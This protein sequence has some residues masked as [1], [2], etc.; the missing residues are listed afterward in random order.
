MKKFGSGNRAT[1]VSPY[2]RRPLRPL[3]KV[4]NERDD[5]GDEG[6]PPEAANSEPVKLTWGRG[7]KTATV[8]D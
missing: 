1:F 6:V 4:L 3:N 5:N 2:L 8:S 7:R